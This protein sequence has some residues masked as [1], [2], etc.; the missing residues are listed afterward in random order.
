MLHSTLERKRVVFTCVGPVERV[1][2]PRAAGPER[3]GRA[4]LDPAAQP[5]H[6]VPV[7]VVPAHASDPAPPELLEQ[8]KLGA[9]NGVAP[10]PKTSSSSIDSA[11]DSSRSNGS[12][13]RQVRGRS[14][15]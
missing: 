15:R 1:H 2:G 14:N 5:A 11:P 13:Q 9:A 12:S 3:R 10:N 6:A 8:L 4:R 7:V